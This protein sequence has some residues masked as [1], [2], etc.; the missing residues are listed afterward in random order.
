MGKEA[1]EEPSLPKHTHKGL[2]PLLEPASA[3]DAVLSHQL[4]AKGTTEQR[5][6]HTDPM[7]NSMGDF[8]GNPT[9]NPIVN[10]IVEPTGIPIGEPS[11]NPIG[12]TTGNSTGD[13]IADPLYSHPMT[14]PI[15]NPTA[16]QAAPMSKWPQAS[17]EV[18]VSLVWGYFC[19]C[20]Q[21]GRGGTSTKG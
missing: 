4:H 15:S 7:G 11:S 18:P 5:Q 1:R 12:D 16:L 8:T 17:R 6:G 9:Q 20:S 13:P 3:V 2:Y 21:H 14:N 19:S 10:L